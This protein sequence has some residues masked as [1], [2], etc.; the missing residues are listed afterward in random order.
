VYWVGRTTGTGRVVV[1]ADVMSKM[2]R[3]YRR[4]KCDECKNLASQ[5][6]A[7]FP[8]AGLVNDPLEENDA[9]VQVEEV[10]TGG[11]TMVPRVLNLAPSR[12]MVQEKA[13]SAMIA[14][15]NPDTVTEV[16]HAIG[17]YQ[18]LQVEVQSTLLKRKAEAE[19]GEAEDMRK[20]KKLEA[21][22]A[23]AN[24]LGEKDL[25][26]KLKKEFADL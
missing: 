8:N 11:D 7:A 23:A 1:R 19:A 17:N 22:I 20:V 25:V 24:R 10:D 26:E 2:L 18:K 15:M 5:L 6:E 4:G 3:D 14:H 13:M 21:K 12:E 9:V 16:C